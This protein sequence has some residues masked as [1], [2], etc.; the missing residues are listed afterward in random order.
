VAVV[1]TSSS[2]Y[3][4]LDGTNYFISTTHDGVSSLDIGQGNWQFG[5]LDTENDTLN[6]VMGQVAI[7]NYSLSTNDILSLWQAAELLPQVAS[8]N[9]SPGNAA[10]AGDTVV[11]NVGAYASG[12]ISYQW[13]TNGGNIDDATN[14]SYTIPDAGTNNS[15]NYTVVL[16]TS[17]GVVTSGIVPLV[18]TVGP[19]VITEQPQ[20]TSPRYTGADVSFSVTA[21]GSPPLTY[22][23][24]LNGVA[25]SG[26]T[27]STYA[28]T[29]VGTNAAGNYTVVVSN[30]IGH[31]YSVTNDLSI[32]VASNYDA[33]I[34]AL[35]PYAYWP[36]NET[37][38]GTAFD[39]AG[40]HGGAIVG[41]MGFAG[42]GPNASQGFNAWPSGSHADY[43]FDG[44]TTYVDCGLN[45][46]DI[47]NNLA[48][49]AWIQFNTNTTQNAYAAI[50]TKGD[51]SWRAALYGT[52]DYIEWDCDGVNGTAYL[53]GSAFDTTDG[54]WHL[55]VANFLKGEMT[56][57][58]DGKP[59]ITQPVSTPIATDHQIH[60]D[61]DYDVL[62]G[63]NAEHPTRIWSGQMA[64]AALFTNGLT[65]AQVAGL[66][67]AAT[68]ATQS[69]TVEIPP[70]SQSVYV[71]QPATFSVLAS[72]ASALAYQWQFEGGIIPGATGDS[73]T[74]ASA[75]YTNNGSYSCLISNSFGQ[76]SSPDADLTVDLLPVFV[77]LTNGLVL[78][79]KFDGDLTDASGNGNYALPGGSPTF[80]AG[81][82]GSGAIHVN[83][84]PGSGIYNYVYVP[85]NAMFTF[86]DFSVSYWVRMAAGSENND[87]PIIGN[88]ANSTYQAGWVMTEDLGQ[89]EWSFVYVS[90][91]GDNRIADPVP[92]GPLIN[93]GNWHQIVV[94][95]SQTND[96]INTFVDGNWIDTEPVGTLGGLAVEAGILDTQQPLTIG[97]DPTGSYTADGQTNL[98]Y[99][100]DDMGVWDR[101][102]S[103]VE[104]ESIYLA[105]QSGQSFDSAVTTLG[106]LTI[107]PRGSKIVV[108]W[109]AGTLMSSSNAN[110]P[111]APVAGASPP[112]YTLTPSARSQFYIL[113]SPGQH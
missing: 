96:V 42:S 10:F 37:S 25:I 32:I 51:D 67:F 14:T 81:R 75:S 44:A 20:G 47:S 41:S 38:G 85:W 69:P 22:Q 40:G 8:L 110:G 100:I 57:F 18:V 4:F 98:A 16:T 91:T 21:V 11:F 74:I 36:L 65:A 102:L 50:M 2:T 113:I 15:A 99:D 107:A 39:Y 66:W 27:N 54:E 88:A 56:L 33:V 7:F 64:N 24:F 60:F 92:T 104:A 82:I 89:T 112:S 87:L 43:I 19:P 12:P 84:V 71:G 90:N 58:E 72:G 73:Y 5:K 79:L 62:I 1:W 77:D 34:M 13:Q 45:T 111:W 108:T 30:S 28:A 101:A 6:A 17:Y 86:T 76:I 29:D 26:A 94:A 97:Q 78:H 83:T 52:S 46:L 55:M 105:G 70:V 95:L 31:V 23:W 53:E 48:L 59:V 9:V 35:N 68:N 109:S 3:V 61:P 106:S 49:V 63:N 103:P 93:D 80:I